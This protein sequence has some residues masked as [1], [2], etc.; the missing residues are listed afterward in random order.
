MR[1]GAG[2]DWVGVSTGW[3]YTRLHYK[4]HILLPSRLSGPE[5]IQYLNT[6]WFK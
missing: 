3:V 5:H 1:Y 4:L 6:L 2:D